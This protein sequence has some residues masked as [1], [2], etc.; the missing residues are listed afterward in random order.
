MNNIRTIIICLLILERLLMKLAEKNL[1]GR[2]SVLASADREEPVE[3]MFQ[4]IALITR[5]LPDRFL[6]W[7]SN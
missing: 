4:S 2:N 5:P 3:P 6:K 7:P 1:K